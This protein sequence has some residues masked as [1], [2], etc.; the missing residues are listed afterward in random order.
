[1]ADAGE[2]VKVGMLF[3]TAVGNQEALMVSD[4]SV[5]FEIDGYLHVEI[6]EFVH[7][8]KTEREKAIDEMIQLDC[9]ATCVEFCEALYD[10]NYRK[11]TPSQA[12]AYD[13][14]TEY[15]GEDYK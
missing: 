13:D 11:L 14:K 5:V 4:K 12:K 3:A 2:K 1:M 6:H 7:P 15:F 9:W 8:I 10:A